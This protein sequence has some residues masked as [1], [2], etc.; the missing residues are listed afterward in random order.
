MMRCVMYCFSCVTDFRRCL[1]NVCT[2]VFARCIVAY[3]CRMCVV[4]FDDCL[5]VVNV[6]YAC[7]ECVSIL[8]V[9]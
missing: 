7:V 6:V 9:S 5:I 1:Y 4:C 2:V 3:A 8:L